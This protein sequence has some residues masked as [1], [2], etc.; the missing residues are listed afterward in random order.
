LKT[1]TVLYW[2]PCLLLGIGICIASGGGFSSAN[3]DGLLF[4]IFHRLFPGST[5]ADWEVVHFAIRK[6]GHWSG[7]GSFALATYFALRKDRWR[8]WDWG[9]ALIALAIVLAL[10]LGDE[11]H[12]SLTPG[13][14]GCLQDSFLDLFGGCCALALLALWNRV[15]RRPVTSRYPV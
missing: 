10:A 3:T 15:V 5:P 11:F 2:I 7:Y 13:R 12:Q 9:K 8:D 6:L 1:R 14:T 4:P